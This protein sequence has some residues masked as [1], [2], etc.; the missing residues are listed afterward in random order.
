VTWLAR[1][2]AE[3]SRRSQLLL[4]TVVMIAGVGVLA[5]LHRTLP[6]DR[7]PGLESQG[8]WILLLALLAATILRRCVVAIVQ[9]EPELVRM[10]VRHAILSLIVLDAAIVAEANHW[11]YGAGVLALY[12]PALL[13]GRWIDS[14]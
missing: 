13:L 8:S 5:L 3:V 11:L 12:F 14:T 4:A 7:I 10:A 9:P 6:E 2:E 1:S